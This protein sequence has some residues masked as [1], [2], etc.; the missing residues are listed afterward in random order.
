[1]GKGNFEKALEQLQEQTDKIK[2]QDI[3]LEDAIKCYEDGMKYYK[4]CSDILENAKQK[5]EMFEG[6]V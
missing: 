2:S 4:V 3:S 5:V 6:E 1:M